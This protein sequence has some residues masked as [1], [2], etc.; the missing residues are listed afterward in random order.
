MPAHV[1]APATSTLLSMLACLA[2]A[3][4]ICVGCPT[5]ALAQSP[6]DSGGAGQVHLG[7]PATVEVAHRE[8]V[9]FRASIMGYSPAERAAAAAQR[10]TAAFAQNPH[11]ELAVLD[12]PE[13]AQVRAEGNALFMVLE[14]DVNRLA[15]ETPH[16]QASAA[17]ERLHLILAEQ[18]ERENP[19]ALLRGLGLAAAATLAWL[20]ALRI[21]RVLARRATAIAAANTE[22]VEVSKLKLFDRRTLF[23]NARRVIRLLAWIL[24]FAT[25]MVWVDA[26]LTSFPQTRPWGED[27]ANV[28]LESL[29]G[30]GIGILKSLPGLCFIVVIGLLASIVLNAAGALFD[31]VREDRLRFGPL[32]RDTARP[33]QMIFSAVVVL[34]AIA[35]AYPYI[36]GSD[37]RALQGL[38]V[39][40]GLMVS[41]GASGTVGH[42]VSGLILMFT[43][44]FRVGDHVRIGDTEGTVTE[45]G[46]FVTRLRSG[47]GEEVQ[48]PNTLV[49]T[50]SSTNFSRA[51]P[52]SAFLLDVVVTIG[53][54]APW[55]LVC[56]M[57]IEAAGRTPQAASDPPPQV[58]QASLDD[59]YVKYRL[60]AHS[61]ATRAE[62]RALARDCLLGNIQDVFNA[63]GVQIMSPHY[64]G[65]PARAKLVPPE[66]WHAVPSAREA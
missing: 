24:A 63:N 3:T 48:L 23:T 37:S 60:V 2:I 61:N 13:G 38:S 57:L 47:L 43:S 10:I 58:M 46:L 31:R 45:L 4:L 25:T 27:L 17:I 39:L 35:M 41:I 64:L 29:K 66:R 16:A 15:G 6:G 22:K 49:L 56:A 65:D 12:V 62:D 34:F 7:E 36:P 5:S 21:I 53:Y 33:L 30:V 1:P 44:A 50:S 18:N 32:D 42:A 26:V 51:T 54:D 11:S 52:G 40:V 28:F 19:R 8:V 20:L 59:F 9:K 14:A 55:R